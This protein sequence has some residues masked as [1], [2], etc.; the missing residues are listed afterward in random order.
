MRCGTK[1]HLW[2]P[3]L[4]SSLMRAQGDQHWYGKS[5]PATFLVD[6]YLL[7]LV[8]LR[9]EYLH[10]ATWEH[11][12]GLPSMTKIWTLAQTPCHKRCMRW[13]LE[14]YSPDVTK[15]HWKPV[16]CGSSSGVPTWV[17]DHLTL[18]ADA[19]AQILHMDHWPKT[20]FW[21]LRSLLHS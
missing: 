12:I 10:L 6:L 7:T 11:L 15:P 17:V 2:K 5:A 8:N 3:Q 14:L 16:T 20:S 19:R 1:C 21:L 13:V 9:T 18:Q 4:D